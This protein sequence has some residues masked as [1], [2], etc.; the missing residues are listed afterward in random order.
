MW[1]LVPMQ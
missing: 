1:P